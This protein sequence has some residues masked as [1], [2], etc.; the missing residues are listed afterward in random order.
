MSYVFDALQRSEA[1]RTKSEIPLSLAATELLEGA[2]RGAAAQWLSEAVA[3]RSPR[4][5]IDRTNPSFWPEGFQ[6]KASVADVPAVEDDSLIKERGECFS[7]FQVLRVPAPQHNLLV[8]L[9]DVDSPA[10]EAFRLLGVRLRHLRMARE[11]KS[12]LITSSVP[13]E[14]KS[15]V[16]ANL[17]CTLASRAQQKV[18]LLEGDVR[19]P[20]LAQLF[21]LPTVPG[22]CN[23]LK[24]ECSVIKSIYRL[25]G[26]GFW[27]LPA[28][29]KAGSPP[30][31]IQSPQLPALMQKLN[32][33]FDW[34]VIDSPPVLPFADTSV[35][36]RLTNGVLFVARRGTSEKRKLQKALEAL[37]QNK[38]IGALLNSSNGTADGDYNYYRRTPGA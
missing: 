15:L 26:P 38:L 31:L 3:E 8:C 34:I 14:G 25:E 22:L 23:Y 37:D 18:L 5:E 33:W 10:A 30:E 35:W 28:G 6:R 17:A 4:P 32:S 2:E 29:D 13:Q 27:I 21:G 9:T 16:A 7:Q 24:S 19:R 1:I 11:L 12:L 36:T 20:S